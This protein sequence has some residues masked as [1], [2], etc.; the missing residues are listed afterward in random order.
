[1][2]EINKQDAI[3]AD[4]EDMLLMVPTPI[5]PMIQ[6][7]DICGTVLFCRAPGIYPTAGDYAGR[8]QTADERR[9][10]G[11]KS[12]K[13]KLRVFMCYIVIIPWT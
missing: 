12:G 9:R 1:M 8:R 4:I 10:A 13:E 5:P 7:D 3:T 6:C 11:L 2:E